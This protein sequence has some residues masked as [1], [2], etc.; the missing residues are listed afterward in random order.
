MITVLVKKAVETTY[1]NIGSTS[2]FT[3]KSGHGIFSID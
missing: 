2:T 1:M 3:E